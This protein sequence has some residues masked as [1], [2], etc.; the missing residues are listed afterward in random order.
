MTVRTNNIFLFIKYLPVVVDDC[1]KRR[2]N[3]AIIAGTSTDNN[4]IRLMGGMGRGRGIFLLPIPLIIPIILM[5]I[6][7][8]SHALLPENASFFIVF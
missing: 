8:H 1:K 3:M 7:V 6:R 5:L 2:L 4:L